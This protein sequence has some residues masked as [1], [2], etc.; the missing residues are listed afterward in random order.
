VVFQDYLLFPHLTA[1]ENVAFGPRSRGMHRGAARE[2]AAR[3]LDAVEVDARAKPRQLSGGQA[4]RVALARAL[5]VDPELLLLDEPLAALDAQT[6][7]TVRSQLRR[8][9]AGFAGS[10][11]V[12]THDPVDAMVL[13]DRLVV[14][15]DG[16][17]VQSGP[18]S[19]VARRPRTPYV[20]RLAGVNLLRGVANGHRV[21]L[22]ESEA[23]VATAN[24]TDGDV[25][26]A[27]RPSAVAVY[28]TRPNGS[29][30]N[31]WAGTVTLTEPLGDAF[32]VH[33]AGPV[34]VTAEVSA[35]AVA[36][37]DLIEGR[38]V[39]VAVKAAEVE[40]YPA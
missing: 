6:R 11:L 22:G 13:A 34:P 36:E 39:W 33:V 32:R 17:A 20:A 21:Y 28:R 8:Q 14:I 1:L 38:K 2:R 4:Q 18:P 3:L 26:V 24:S 5:A 40:A 16:V 29:P 12:V 31:V 30:R 7:L 25:F 23:V 10:A 35:A 15:E 37:L 9:L 27:F 19:E